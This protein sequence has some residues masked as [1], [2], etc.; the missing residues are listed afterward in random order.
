[1]PASPQYS[2]VS[3]GSN[4]RR[5]LTLPVEPPVV[6]TTALRALANGAFVIHRNAEHAT[7]PR[8]F[9]MNRGH[10]VFEQNL[11]AGL[12]RRGF[13]RPDQTC[14]GPD[15]GV[16]WIGG[17]PGMDHR[18]IGNVDLHRA[19]YRDA[20]L[21]SD[22]VRRPVDDAYPVS[23]QEFERGHAVVGKGADDLAI[24]IAI[25]REAIV[26]DHGPIGQIAEK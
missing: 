7:A 25:R 17:L 24:V 10:A 3:R 26:L 14:S 22:I 19:W 23:E 20:D 8:R 12:A 1:M 2:S 4:M 6:T 15:F 18:P 21:V 13:Q 9:A 5:K 16:V 11:D